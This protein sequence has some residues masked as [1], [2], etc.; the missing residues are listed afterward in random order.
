LNVIELWNFKYSEA[1]L[2]V[3]LGDINND[4]QI[5]IV[6]STESGTLIIISQNGKLLH[7]ETLSK[8]SPIWHLKIFDIN[9]NGENELISGGMDGIL[10]VYKSSSTNALELFWK[11]KFNSSISGFLLNDIN[12]DSTNEIIVFSLDKTLR[13]LNSFNGDLVWGQIFENGIGGAIIFIDHRYPIKKEII[14]C[15]NDGTVRGYNAGNGE[16]LW[17]KVFTNNIRCVSI[18]NSINSCIILCGGDDKQ[19]H[20]L[21]KKTLKEIKIKEFNEYVWKCI[22]YPD[23]IFN[24][25]VISSYS[26]DYFDKSIKFENI[27]FKSNLICINEFLDVIWEIKGYNIEFLDILEINNKNLILV[28]TTKGE[29]ILI[30]EKTAEILLYRNN[31]SCINMIQFHSEDKKLFCCHD[32]GSVIAYKLEGI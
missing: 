12:N 21:D 17:F 9:N 31:N 24:K 5:E 29:L 27:G 14:A 20:F 28:G 13:V 1:I 25:A 4:G 7:K 22:S 23:P 15:G 32:N 6:A 2:G 30:E 8:N 19:L 16:L 10:K 26:F 11:H 18:L 3:E